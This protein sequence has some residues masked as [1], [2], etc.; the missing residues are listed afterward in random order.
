MG[1]VNLP[2]EIARL[3][4]YKSMQTLTYKQQEILSYIANT[5]AAKGAAPTYQ[6][7]ARAFNICIGTVQSHLRSLQ[8]KGFVRIE[9]G[10][11]RGLRLLKRGPAR[12]RGNFDEQIG[13]K[14]RG[15]TDL[16]QLFALVREDLKAWLGVDTAELL[17]H[18]VNRKEWRGERLKAGTDD[19]ALS[20]LALRRRKPVVR[21]G[22][23]AIPVLGR[24]RVLG[25]LRLNGG[26]LDR[27][28]L[29]RAS[30]AAAALVP[31][32][33]QGT[34]HA[35]LQR[36][37]KL[38]A[39]LISLVRSVNSRADLRRIVHDVREIVCS[40]VDAP[41]FI[42]AV[43][44][45]L[46]Q[47]WFLMQTDII[48]GKL[49]IDDAPRAQELGRHNAL[50][51]LQTQ[52]YYIKHRTPEEVRELEAREPRPGDEWMPI[53]DVKKRSRSIL[54]V[55]LK[56]DGRMIGYLSAQSY[57]YNAYSIQ[58]AEDLI[59]IG[60]YIGLAVHQAWREGKLRERLEN[61]ER[62]LR[63]LAGSDPRLENLARELAAI[64][65]EQKGLF[66]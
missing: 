61:V 3:P 19:A 29:S 12:W 40:L 4:V 48:D 2:H 64:R 37:I 14:L 66:A 15:E 26:G 5:H 60:E 13:R 35:E 65:S 25:V 44:D 39:A 22:A 38:Q 6:E 41:C 7:I 17:L 8:K 57:R 27:T 43:R 33:E 10:V 30:V 47:W 59:L 49:W 23:A 42:I 9:P 28:A 1:P 32:I 52:P 50:K 46:N 54:Y 51:V 58:D 24:D 63:N 18:D 16:H 34:L 21:D 53:G 11:H 36:R 31:A 56:T 62:E 20:D 45:E 55:P